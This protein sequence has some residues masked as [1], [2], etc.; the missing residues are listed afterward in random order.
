MA[1]QALPY[2]RKN[3]KTSMDKARHLDLIQHYI[4]N[5]AIGTTTL[6]NQGADGIADAAREF[7]ACL[8]ISELKEKPVTEYRSWLDKK[9]K[10]LMK[11]FPSGAKKDWGGARKAMNLLMVGAYFNK[12]L[13]KKY[14]L[15]RFEND[16]E[17]PLDGGAAERIREYGR[18]KGVEWECKLCSKDARKSCKGQHP[19]CGKS[20]FPG[21]VNLK[22]YQSRGYQGIA[23]E[24][25]KEIGLPRA[26]L[27]IIL[28]RKTGEEWKEF[29]RNIS[30]E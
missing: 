27:D 25:A 3:A 10:E 5:V 14:K 17:T 13:S 30:R 7:L 26:E 20:K 21:I 15:D 2:K 29:L 23:T 28:W 18:K 22:D 6:R 24:L 12:V 11:K 9:T 16:L 4:A 19:R 1:G 8:D